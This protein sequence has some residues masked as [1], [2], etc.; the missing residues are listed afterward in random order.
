VLTIRRE[1][2]GRIIS[3]G[4]AFPEKVVGNREL[5][6]D[7]GVARDWIERRC[8]VLRRSVSCTE[9]ATSLGAEAARRTLASSDERPDLLLCATYSA[10]RLLAPIA[11]RIARQ[12]GLNQIAAFDLNAACSGGIIAFISALAFINSGLCQ[13]VLV[14]VADTVCTFLS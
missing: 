2:A 4:L 6:I 8:G 7:F 13:R 1:L 12:A 11:P 14:I 10:D 9:I 5:A 3:T